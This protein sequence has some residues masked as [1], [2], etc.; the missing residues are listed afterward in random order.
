MRGRDAQRIIAV[1]INLDRVAVLRKRRP[2]P[3]HRL[4]NDRHDEGTHVDPE[5]ETPRSGRVVGDRLEPGADRDAIRVIGQRL[6]KP[7]HDLV[8]IRQ[9]VDR[10]AARDDRDV[11]LGAGAAKAVAGPA[12]PHD[13]D[14]PERTRIDLDARAEL[15][16]DLLR[17]LGERLDRLADLEEGIV[18]RG[19]VGRHEVKRHHAALF[20]LL[21]LA[22][23]LPRGAVANG[24]ASDF[25]AVGE[26]FPNGS[27]PGR[28]DHEVAYVPSWCPS[29]P[30]ATTRPGELIKEIGRVA[31]AGPKIVISR[32]AV[33]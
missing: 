27:Q 1:E 11:G 12:A 32:V 19:G 4:R 26:E 30:E 10:D 3:R 2:R 17:S 22:P 23:T 29:A 33:G 8:F 18:A 13:R 6:R 15:Q 28:N 5:V 21:E 24:A 20:E 25:S 9:S 14:R 16:R 7:D 31:A